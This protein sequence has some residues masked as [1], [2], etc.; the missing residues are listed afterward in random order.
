MLFMP[1]I[2]RF[3]IAWINA[4]TKREL[5]KRLVQQETQNVRMSK[6]V[7]CCA[8]ASGEHHE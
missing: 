4:V 5:G 7:K 2:N 3:L 6:S 1:L 8:N